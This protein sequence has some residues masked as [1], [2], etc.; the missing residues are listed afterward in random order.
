MSAPS[1]LLGDVSTKTAEAPFGTADLP[2]DVVN[3][4]YYITTATGDDGTGRRRVPWGL[5]LWID[6]GEVH[7]G[8]PPWPR[9]P[10]SFR[11]A[12]GA[13]LTPH[14]RRM[15]ATH[16]RVVADALILTADKLP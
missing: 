10:A 7:V 14:E 1:R 3:E 12:N 9:D 4:R 5:W 15:V 8:D 6:A 16:L 11:G 13:G 2:D